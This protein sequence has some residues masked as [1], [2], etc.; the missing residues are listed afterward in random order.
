MAGIFWRLNQDLIE[1][2]IELELLV[3]ESVDFVLPFHLTL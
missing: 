3:G 1:I 2:N